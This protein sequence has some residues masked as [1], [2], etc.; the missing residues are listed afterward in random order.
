MF[1]TIL[2][3]HFICR[4]TYAQ[5]LVEIDGKKSVLFADTVEVIF[6]IDSCESR[7][8]PTHD[9]AK[10]TNRL[11]VENSGYFIDKYGSSFKRDLKMGR[12]QF[13]G[14]NSK[15]LH[16]HVILILLA[17]RGTREE[18]IIQ[19]LVNKASYWIWRFLRKECQNI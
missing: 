17:E 13:I 4:S 10:E 15:T 11:L 1:T 9:D 12:R 5:E 2:F 14:F 19:R 6:F 8:M 18:K 3:C 16:R 7:F